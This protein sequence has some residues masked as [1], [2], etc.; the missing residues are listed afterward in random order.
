MPFVSLFLPSPTTP[1][2]LPP[3][4]YAAWPLEFPSPMCPL[5]VI[6]LSLPC[7][8]PPNTH[9]ST[10]LPV[11]MQQLNRVFRMAKEGVYSP[12]WT[13]GSWVGNKTIN[14]FKG[15][16]CTAFPPIKMITILSCIHAD[17]TWTNSNY[18]CSKLGRD[19]S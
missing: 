10:F 3:S 4:I 14:H 12:C 6:F 15:G 11:S 9:Q 17:F 19:S 13:L 18:W 1:P 2:S 8:P 16:F 5:L 7:P